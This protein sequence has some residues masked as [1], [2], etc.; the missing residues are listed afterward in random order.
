MW[1]IGSQRVLLTLALEYGWEFLHLDVKTGFSQRRIE[2]PIYVK[3]SPGN[4]CYDEESGE[5]LVMKLKTVLYGLFKVRQL[6]SKRWMVRCK[7]SGSW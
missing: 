4:Q 6:G 1:R 2:E 7:R 5:P 3:M